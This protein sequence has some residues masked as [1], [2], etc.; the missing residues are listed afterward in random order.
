VNEHTEQ[1]EHI[2]DTIDKMKQLDFSKNINSVSENSDLNAIAT[3]LNEMSTVLEQVISQEKQ[4]KTIQSCILETLPANIALINNTGEITL[5]NE[6]W[7]NFGKQNGVHPEHNWIGVNYLT[8]SE[9]CKGDDKENAKKVTE[10]LRKILKGE[11]DHFAMEYSC[12]SSD[13]KRWFIVQARP[14][15]IKKEKCALVMHINITERKLF[16][17]RQMAL[18]DELE[19]KVKDR[20]LELTRLLQNEKKVNELKNRLVTR[21]SHEFR[22]PLA[23]ILSSASLIEG[24]TKSEQQENRM[25]HVNLITSSVKNL[26]EILTSFQSLEALE[27]N[28]GIIKNTEINLPEFIMT[29]GKEFSGILSEKNQRIN[30][31]HSGETIIH[32]SGEILRNILVNLLSNASKYSHKEI[33]LTS[34]VENDKVSI[35]VVDNGIGIPEADQS[36]LFGQYYRAANAENIPGTGLGLSIVKN[37]IELINGEVTFVSKPKEGTTFT[38]EFPRKG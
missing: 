29:I 34:S 18:N 8:I 15:E 13:K 35:S 26:T 10:G 30:Y 12:H 9:L 37:Y 11:L 24:Y 38:I 31:R 33:L 32:Q 16:E 7:N 23:L 28:N 22:T 6:G 14:I 1:L 25:K 2:L 21:V 19:L 27:K 4:A 5:T 17:E 36:K 3:R 20:T